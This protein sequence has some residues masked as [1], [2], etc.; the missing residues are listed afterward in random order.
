VVEARRQARVALGGDPNQGDLYDAQPKK[1]SALLSASPPPVASRPSE[2]I[3][4]LSLGEAA[5]RLGISR[6]K[7]EKMIE[8]GTIKALPTG[9]TR[10]IPRREV[11][12]LIGM[13]DG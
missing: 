11:Q 5:I 12:R 8:A 3:P 2:A 10:M 4:V 6:A 7:L 1:K 9:Y 13:G